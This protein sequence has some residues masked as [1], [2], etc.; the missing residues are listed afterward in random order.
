MGEK[1]WLGALWN[2]QKFWV[3]L[4]ALDI[5]CAVLLFLGAM[6]GWDLLKLD[7][8]IFL[9]YI[10][11]ITPPIIINLFLPNVRTVYI[12]IAMILSIIIATGSWFFLS[13]ESYYDDQQRDF[14]N[15]RDYF[16]NVLTKVDAAEQK[17]HFTDLN[18]LKS[19]FRYDKPGSKATI[20]VKR[21]NKTIVN[22]L[23]NRSKGKNPYILEVSANSNLNITNGKE[24]A[25]ATVNDEV[26][27]GNNYKLIYEY[28]N[29]PESI[30]GFIRAITFSS[31]KDKNNQI[32]LTSN[33]SWK[34][35]LNNFLYERSVNFWLMFYACFFVAVAIS[36]ML[37]EYEREKKD[38]EKEEKH[39][40][41]LE[42]ANDKLAAANKKLDQFRLMYRK[43]FEDYEEAGIA[44]NKQVLQSID[45]TWPKIVSKVLALE[46][47][48]LQNSFDTMPSGL[49]A[50]EKK[51]YDE[52]IGKAKINILNNL[53]RLP[54]IISYET[55]PTNIQEV[56]IGLNTELSSLFDIYKKIDH[57]KLVF[58]VLNMVPQTTVGQCD[59][60]I[61]RLNSMVKNILVNANAQRTKYRQALKDEGKEYN[62][63]ITLSYSLNIDKHNQSCLCITVKDNAGGFSKEIESEVYVN[64]VL[65]SK[66]DE[67]GNS[68][69]G[70]GTMYVAFFAELMDI[71]IDS[72]N[73]NDEKEKGAE[74]TLLIPIKGEANNG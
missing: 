36:Y 70:E 59:V 37:G 16:K 29:R 51:L 61:H 13:H 45:F 44:D 20:I 22:I 71:E 54:N 68:R 41:E 35:Y 28:Y 62:G 72:H 73:W 49:D 58:T 56:I 50:L 48:D 30:T 55:T 46:R 40:K 32:S 43:M 2:K 31:I 17:G 6:S 14:A 39:R 19:I 10:F 7:Y 9:L 69:Q 53:R 74:V 24:I 8:R 3:I 60:N 67:N 1:S 47:H 27:V 33:E 63:K 25:K 65:S 42:I 52:V 34:K 12:S 64:P 11:W 57:K 23:S 18:V 15:Q 66:L 38:K 21:D 26:Q 5:L 4:L